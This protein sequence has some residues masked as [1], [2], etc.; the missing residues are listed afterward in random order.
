[1]GSFSTALRFKNFQIARLCSVFAPRS[2]KKLPRSKK[3]SKPARV[4][5]LDFY[6]YEKIQSISMKKFVL[7]ILRSFLHLFLVIGVVKA[8]TWSDN[9]QNLLHQ[10]TIQEK[11]GQMTQLTS[12]LLFEGAPYVLTVPYQFDQQKLQKAIVQ[13]GVGSILNIPAQSYPGPEEWQEIV[14]TIQN[15]TKQT[16]LKI[17]VVYGLDHTHGVSYIK[18]GT[19]FPQPLGV[20]CSWNVDLAEEIGV[21]SGYESRAAGVPWSFSPAMD[22]GRNPEWPR[23]WESYGEDVLLNTLMGK[24]MV[25]GMQGSDPS[26][27]NKIAACLKHFTGYG[28]PLS[29][30]DRTP[31]W[32]PERYLREYFLP[33]YQASIDAG[34]LSIMVNSGEINGIPTHADKHL[35]TDILRTEM[36]FEGVLVSDWADIRYLFERHKIAK[37][38]KE[39]VKLAIDAGLD[40]SMTPVTYDFA[41][42]LVELVK[43]GAISE[44]R[45]D[46]SVG[47]ILTMKEKLGLFKD[48]P[49]LS[50]E[51][52]PNFGSE[53]FNAASL[54]GA[55]ESLVLLKNEEHTLPIS[56]S[57]RVLVVGPTA[58]SMASLNGGWT[59][60]WQGDQA[61]VA[62]AD[63]NSVLEGI[64]NI[65]GE[66]QVSYV[67]GAQYD[68]ITSAS[69]AVEAAKEVDYIVLCLGELS[70]TEDW[71]NLNELQL[72]QA[73]LD[74]AQLLSESGKPI[75]LVLTEG[76]PR[77]I[78]TIEPLANAIIGAFY[79]GPNGGD[80][81]AKILYGDANPSGK[82]AFT[83]P[84]YSNA[85]IPY[86][87]KETEDRDV[88]NSGKSFDPQFSFGFGLSYT[89]FKYSNLKLDKKIYNESEAITI[90]VDVKNTGERAGKE[91]VQL[92]VRDEIASITPPV[93]RLR[94]FEKVDLAAGET[95]TIS[96]QVPVLDLAFVG[97][98]NK[99][100]VEPGDFTL[101]VGGLT[102]DFR[103]N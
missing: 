8:Q 71:G 59:V 42:A 77:I 2:V 35:L 103:V 62:L 1:M 96:F 57:S 83:Y 26:T 87:H 27:K 99:W 15:K 11:V 3:Q 73:Q 54:E 34:A 89:T 95:Q 46:L 44:E 52:Y 41:D 38:I 23:L 36:G 25:E 100:V 90:T 40:M 98:E 101:Q 60:N 10:M 13:Y 21:I 19:L 18:G 4:L 56:K 65:G 32:I 55:I 16:R 12:D 72:P 50:V 47:R 29:G 64:Q 76:R 80:A 63:Y 53:E 85:L 20:A 17:P 33:Q 43:E 102:K 48:M 6:L 74:L 84:R 14:T 39:A 31:A 66:D 94:A 75:I 86:D 7:P 51:D 88:Q 61:N 70:Y 5:I 28:M 58:E 45:I 24:A 37:D 67:K 69:A 93:K 97:L 9:V 81:I 92:Y 79:P 49:P 68:Q 22:I 78:R 82:L 30:K 91:V